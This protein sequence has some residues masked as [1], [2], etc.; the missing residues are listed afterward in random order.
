MALIVSKT[1]PGGASLS[2]RLLPTGA[3]VT[4]SPLDL[5]SVRDIERT[6]VESF[7]GPTSLRELAARCARLELLVRLSYE[8]IV[9]RRM[10]RGAGSVRVRRDR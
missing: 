7:C 6:E 1:R 9:A 5:V 3:N 10:A 4:T 2:P 8:A